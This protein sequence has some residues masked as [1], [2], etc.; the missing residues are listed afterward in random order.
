MEAEIGLVLHFRMLRGKIRG[1]TGEDPCSS[2]QEPNKH[3]PLG[4]QVAK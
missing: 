2:G 1:R 4:H 3:G